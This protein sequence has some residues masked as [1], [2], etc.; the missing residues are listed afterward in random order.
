MAI[1]D[2]IDPLQK[3]IPDVMQRMTLGGRSGPGKGRAHSRLMSRLE[4]LPDSIRPCLTDCV[5]HPTGPQNLIGVPQTNTSGETVIHFE[6][7]G[8]TARS[9]I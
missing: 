8:V 2:F 6:M 9:A 3:E 5:F 7:Y 1:Y 4:E